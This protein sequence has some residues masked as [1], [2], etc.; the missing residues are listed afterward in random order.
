MSAA[1]YSRRMATGRQEAA[2]ERA[3]RGLGA[4]PVA[5]HVG[6]PDEVWIFCSLVEGRKLGEIVAP[7]VG[8]AILNEH[9]SWSWQMTLVSTKYVW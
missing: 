6:P 3:R 1:D 2:A 8:V 5:P 9:G 7:P 4:T